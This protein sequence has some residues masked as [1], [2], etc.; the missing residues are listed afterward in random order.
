MYRILVAPL[1]WGL[2]HATRC[3]ALIRSLRELH[4][5]VLIAADG[6]QAVLLA[7]EFP[8]LTILKLKGYKIRYAKT[9]W[10][11]Y[12]KLMV[13]IPGILKTI[14]EEH[15]WLQ[16]LIET[17]RIDLVISDNRYGLYSDKVPCI[18]L[19]HQLTIKAPFTFIELMLRKINYHYINRFTACWIPDVAGEKNVAGL[20]SHPSTLPKIPIHYLGLLTRVHKEKA[21]PV[22]HYC[23]I[24]SGPEPQRSILESMILKALPKISGKVLLIR[25]LPDSNEQI[26]SPKNTRVYNHLS[27]ADMQ[28]AIQA[29]EMVICRSGYTS[30][31]ELISLQKKALIIP[32]PGQTEQEYLSKRLMKELI[33]YSVA[34]KNLH[35]LDDLKTANSFQSVFPEISFFTTKTLEALLRDL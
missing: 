3:I 16:Q 33:F 13:Q 1:D 11:L 32:T 2:G 18:F 21:H 19:T 31:M 6:A 28:D 4:Y 24:L 12:Q 23:F 34:Q 27:T 35:L 20:L 22:Y 10:G 17:H 29:S 14:R 15:A 26:A 25:G 5:E 30:L 8:E 7:A 9:T